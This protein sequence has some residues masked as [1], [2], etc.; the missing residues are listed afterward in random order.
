MG[1]RR[2]GSMA[3]WIV[4]FFSVL[5]EIA[6]TAGVTYTTGGLG[7]DWDGPA[8]FSHVCT[9]PSPGLPARDGALCDQVGAWPP[10]LGAIAHAPTLLALHLPAGP[11]PATRT[12][13]RAAAILISQ[14]VLLGT[15]GAGAG[16][17]ALEQRTIVGIYIG[18]EIVLGLV[19]TFSVRLLD[20]VGEI[21]VWY[22]VVGITAFVIILPAIAPHHQP[23]QWVFGMFAPDHAY[24]GVRNGAFS[25][26]LALLG[27]QWAMVG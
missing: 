21:S 27:S 24:S 25:F 20:L 18:V 23:A 13:T 22:H 16:G 15:G 1:G 14:Y 2:F 6:A 3:A 11:N 9:P 8:A 7:G 26:L 5:G 19:N 17:V 10:P 4:G 12:P